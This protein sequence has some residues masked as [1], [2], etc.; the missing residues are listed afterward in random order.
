MSRNAAATTSGALVRRA[1]GAVA[2]TRARRAMAEEGEHI[3]ADIAVVVTDI[4]ANLGSVNGRV[5]CDGGPDGGRFETLC[6]RKV[7]AD[8]SAVLST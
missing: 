4:G 5:R 3:T 2:R 8:I 6:S 1:P 7:G